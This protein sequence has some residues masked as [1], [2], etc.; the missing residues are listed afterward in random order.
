MFRNLQD[1]DF[2]FSSVGYQDL[3]FEMPHRTIY[4]SSLF[5]LHVNVKEFHD[6]LYLLD[7]CFHKLNSLHVRISNIDLIETTGN[8]IQLINMKH[9]NNLRQ[10]AQIVTTNRLFLCYKE[11]F[12]DG[13]NLK[14]DILSRLSHLQQFQFNIYSYIPVDNESNL[15][16]KED[17][18]NTL[19]GVGT[20]E[21]KL[22]IN[23]YP[24][25]QMGSCHIYS[26]LSSHRMKYY[27][28]ITNNFPGGL[29]QNV[30]KISLFDE[31]PFEHEFFIRIAQSFPFLQSLSLTNMMPQND[32]QDSS[33]VQFLHL[34]ELNFDEIHDDY[35]EQFLLDTKTHLSNDISLSIEYKQLQRVTH[36]FTRIATKSNCAKLGYKLCYQN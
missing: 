16:S 14:Y 11:K 32:T 17:I 28:N 30:R 26:Y 5:K 23:Y 9:F 27:F 2:G 24:K 10:K 12:I 22:L 15:P 13:D 6:C 7:D 25:S 8:E 33:I 29:Y 35:A 34:L 18:E 31:Y 20:N 36:N 19:I 1:L 21:I 3:S 4:S